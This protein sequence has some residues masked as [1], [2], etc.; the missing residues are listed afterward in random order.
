MKF[1]RNN[2]ESP[3]VKH[4]GREKKKQIILLNVKKKYNSVEIFDFK[5]LWLG[6]IFLN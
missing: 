4:D 5:I 6:R 2:N 3:L 1:L